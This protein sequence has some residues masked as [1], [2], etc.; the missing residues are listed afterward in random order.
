MLKII[1]RCSSKNFRNWKVVAQFD[2]SSVRFV[3]NPLDSLE[4]FL[5]MFEKRK[6][7]DPIEIG[8]A[9]VADGFPLANLGI[10]VA[11]EIVS[12]SK[13][14]FAAFTQRGCHNECLALISGYW[15]AT[16]DTNPASCAAR[17]LLEEFLVYQNTRRVFLVPRGITFPYKEESWKYSEKWKLSPRFEALQWVPS[18]KVKAVGDECRVYIDATTSSA[19]V[20]YGYCAEFTTWRDLSILHAEDRAEANGQLVTF[21]KHESIVLFRVI[22]NQLVGNPYWLTQGQLVPVTLPNNAYFH[23]SMVGANQLGIVSSDRIP[24]REVVRSM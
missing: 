10:S 22:E 13:E 19:Q 4:T 17:E 20:V 24:L 15:D 2:Q 12:P 3:I 18:A 11:L 21:I 9:L 14:R 23:P 5:E 8:K 6:P 7:T 16:H 1:A